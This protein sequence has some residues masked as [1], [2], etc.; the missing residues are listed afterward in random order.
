VTGPD[1]PE[2][3]VEYLREKIK[4]VLTDP[5]VMEEGAKTKR[6]VRYEAPAATVKFVKEV[7]G[8]LEGE[9]LAAVRHVLLEK[10]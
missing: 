3:R 7:L 10:Y 4:A 8:S 6:D 2:D 5:A 9:Q 1:V